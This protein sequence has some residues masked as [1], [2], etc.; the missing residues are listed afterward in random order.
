MARGCIVLADAPA[1]LIELCGISVLERLLR[2]LQ[3]CGIARATIASQTPEAIRAHLVSPSW[4][5]KELHIDVKNAANAI[6]DLAQSGDEFFLVVRGDTIFDPRLLQLLLEQNREVALADVAAVLHRETFAKLTRVEIPNGLPKIDIDD[7]PQY[8]AALRRNLRSFYFSPAALEDKSRVE[9][10]LIGATQK[11][12]QDFPAIL[13]APIEKFLVARLCQTLITPHQLTVTWI[14][15]AFAVT[16]LFAT[17]HFAWGIAL[18]FIIGILDGLDGKLARLRVETSNIGKLEHRFDSFFEVAWPSAIALYLRQ[19]SQ[20]PNALA[21]LALLIAGQIVDGLAKGAIYNAFAQAMQP[22]NL[23]DRVV[24][25]FGG[26]RNVVV[27]IFLIAVL[28]GA[29]VT[30]FIVMAWWQIATAIVDLAHAV[31]LRSRL[32]KSQ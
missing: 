17:G 28:F 7:L 27:W 32:R 8:S 5:R 1:A 16:A 3:R 15:L 26:R 24:R 19:S 31:W 18:A 4:A 23:L 13:H 30:G 29:P 6:V 10:E 21:Y 12:A 11:G 2:T 20:L 22:S 9:R 14:I 25:F